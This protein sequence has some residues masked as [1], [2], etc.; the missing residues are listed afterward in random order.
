MINIDAS[1]LCHVDMY[2]KI[3]VFFDPS[4]I[5]SA[6]SCRTDT[7]AELDSVCSMAKAAGAFDAVVC[8]HWAEGGAGA[9][10]LGQ[11]VQRASGAPSNF[12]F[13]YD[14]EV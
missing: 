6:D 3:L 9:L 4:S 14:L 7:E 12:K 13:L 8:S 11:A 1:V 5:F 2:W 10:A